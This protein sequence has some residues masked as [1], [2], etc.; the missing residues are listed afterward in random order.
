[1]NVKDA[2]TAEEWQVVGAAPFL[3]GMYLVGVTPSG[4]IVIVREMLTAEKAVALEAA[5]P[6]GLPLVKEIEADLRS[7][8]LT[9]DFG[10]ISGAADTQAR[11]LHELAHA[12][13]LV[14]RLAPTMDSAYRAW[15][16]RLAEKLVR[17][18]P[19]P[20]AHSSGRQL[21]DPEAAALIHLAT[22]LGVP[23]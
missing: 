11:V 1:M 4:P 10:R 19:E 22:T 7:Q 13:A 9:R 21:S 2:F 17:V 23:R 18:M 14:G 5:L 3:V 20:G 12:L 15:L 6:D 8:V 16:Y